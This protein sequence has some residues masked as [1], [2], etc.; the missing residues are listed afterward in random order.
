M[1]EEEH[2]AKVNRQ[3]YAASYAAAAIRHTMLF[4]PDTTLPPLSPPLPRCLFILLH[5]DY[6]CYYA[7]ISIAAFFMRSFAMM[8]SCDS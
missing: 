3:C 8:L 1:N 4:S 5:A 7:A 6:A 2:R